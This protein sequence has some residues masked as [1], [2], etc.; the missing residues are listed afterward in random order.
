MSLRL[1]CCV[2]QDPILGGGKVGKTKPKREKVIR[3]GGGWRLGSVILTALSSEL[4]VVRK[5]P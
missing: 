1:A 3:G 4:A 2:S 5:T